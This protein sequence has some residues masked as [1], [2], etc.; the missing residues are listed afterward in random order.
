M[1]RPKG[2]KNK[3]TLAKEAIAACAGCMSQGSLEHSLVCQESHAKSAGYTM[4]SEERL[5][6]TTINNN[7]VK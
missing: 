7:E 1:G 3:K 6:A 2:S 5:S 4:T